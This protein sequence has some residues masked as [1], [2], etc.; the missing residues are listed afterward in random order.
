[1]FNRFAQSARSAMEETFLMITDKLIIEFRASKLMIS[2][3][4]G[5]LILVI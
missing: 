4:T 1:M 3:G 5:E 2:S